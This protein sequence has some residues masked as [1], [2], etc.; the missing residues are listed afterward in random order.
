[1][2]ADGRLGRLGAK[3][4]GR[5]KV[6][7]GTFDWARWEAKGFLLYLDGIGSIVSLQQSFRR[8]FLIVARPVFI[9]AD[10]VFDCRKPPKTLSLTPKKLSQ[11]SILRYFH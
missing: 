11:N 2:E 5:W 1:M 6:G 4:D 9:V 10:P 8:V 3:L 7:D